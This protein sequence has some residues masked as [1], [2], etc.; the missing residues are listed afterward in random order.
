MALVFDNGAFDQEDRDIVLHG[1]N[2]FAAR[3]AQSVPIW[4]DYQR[5]AAGRAGQ[6]VDEVFPVHPCHSIRQACG[7]EVVR[8]ASLRL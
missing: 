1:I 8:K 3:A 7:H 4:A 6:L 2:A 5:V